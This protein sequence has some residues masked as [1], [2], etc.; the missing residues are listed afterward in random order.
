MRNDF[1]ILN[2]PPPVVWSCRRRN[3]DHSPTGI[4]CNHRFP[5]TKLVNVDMANLK[6]CLE[7]SW[8]G[9]KCCTTTMYIPICAKSMDIYIY[10]YTYTCKGNYYVYVNIVNILCKYLVWWY[11]NSNLL[12]CSTS[13]FETL[14]NF[15]RRHSRTNL[16]VSHSTKENLFPLKEVPPT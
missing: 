2:Q 15:T 6:R 8:L 11:E 10:K 1:P 5:R 3:R 9:G 4:C 13:V 14:L 12:A 16:H 7:G